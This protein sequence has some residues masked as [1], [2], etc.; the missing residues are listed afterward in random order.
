MRIMWLK[1]PSVICSPISQAIPSSLHVIQ[2]LVRVLAPLEFGV[3]EA[4]VQLLASSVATGVVLFLQ[5]L[6]SLLSV[7]GVA[8]HH[9]SLS[10][11]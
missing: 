11:S 7:S 9:R 2:E 10:R 5:R 8:L 1:K 3:A 6:P 4:V